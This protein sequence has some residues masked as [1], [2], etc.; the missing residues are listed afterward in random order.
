MRRVADREVAA[1]QEGSAIAAY[2]RMDAGYRVRVEWDIGGLKMKWRRLMKRFDSSN[3]KFPYLF[4]SSAILTNF[5]HC[6]RLD[7]SYE[8]LG[9]R[10]EEEGMHGWHGDF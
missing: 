2:N 4:R 8:V 6:H 3:P 10:V 7:L 9:G 5:L 1:D